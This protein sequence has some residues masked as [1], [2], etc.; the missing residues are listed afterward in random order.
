MS[1]SGKRDEWDRHNRDEATARAAQQLEAGP[2]HE[3]VPVEPYA[4]LSVQPHARDADLD[5]ATLI[6]EYERAVV[7]ERKE[8]LLARASLTETSAP[9]V[10]ETWRSAVECSQRAAL[11]LVN[12]GTARFS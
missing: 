8:W 3:P 2:L 10:W 11:R 9:E 5:L 4:G 6:D 12:Y 7:I 1:T